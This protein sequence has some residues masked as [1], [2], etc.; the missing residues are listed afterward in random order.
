VITVND[1]L[2]LA[3]RGLIATMFFASA[4]DKFRLDPAELRQIESLHLP[5]PKVLAILVG[6]FEVAAGA[7]LVLGVY[8]RL[9]ALILALFVAVV[10]VLFVRFWSFKGAPETRTLLRNVFLAN[11]AVTGGLIC[12]A[13]A[14]PGKLALVGF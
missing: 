7:G 10:S 14:G 12:L 5:V 8:L 9:V 2:L 13:V 1:L 3:A 4:R 6:T 11:C